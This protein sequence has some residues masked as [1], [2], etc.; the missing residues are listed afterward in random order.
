MSDCQTHSVVKCYLVHPIDFLLYAEKVGTNI[1]SQQYQGIYYD[2]IA[3]LLSD[4]GLNIIL[5][6][7]FCRI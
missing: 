7:T 4:L 6:A 2:N 5:S 1:K 3:K